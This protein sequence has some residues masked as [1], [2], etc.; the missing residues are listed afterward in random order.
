MCL[1]SNQQKRKGSTASL[2]IDSRKGSTISLDKVSHK[3]SMSSLNENIR[4][5][6]QLA[7]REKYS[8]VK[9]K[10]KSLKHFIE[11]N[12]QHIFF[13][14]IFFG[15]CLAVAGERFYCEYT[16][17]FLVLMYL[18]HLVVNAYG[19]GVLKMLVCVC[20]MSYVCRPNN[21]INVLLF[22]TLTSK[23]H[24]YSQ[25]MVVTHFFTFDS[26][27]TVQTYLKTSM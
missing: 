9:A 19:F 10:I 3:G 2:D 25:I 5:R 8:P 6:L 15:I 17:V 14:I 26:L 4:P 13:L 27:L 7:L 22:P 18:I 21:K 1:I 24:F 12:K 11:N 20:M 23:V 16:V